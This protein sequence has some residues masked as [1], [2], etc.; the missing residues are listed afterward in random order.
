LSYKSK[1]A[2]ILLELSVIL[3]AHN[4]QGTIKTA[5]YSTLNAMPKNSELLVFLDAC[6][7]E[8]EVVLAAVLDSRLRVIKS[9]VNLGVSGAL[10]TLLSEA[11]GN[12]VARMDADD[13]CLPWRF[14]IQLRA[15]KKT[16]ADF[17]F[18][19]AVLFGRQLRPFGFIA[20][21][22]LCLKPDQIDMA[23]IFANPFVHPSMLAKR[24]ALEELGGY[25]VSAA[26]DYELWLRAALARKRMVRTW[27]YGL[28][29]RVHAGQLTQQG[30]W[31]AK[32]KTD[33]LLEGAQRLLAQRV[34]GISDASE[35]SAGDLREIAWNS[36]GKKSIRV[37]LDLL[38]NIGFQRYFKY[39]IRG[40]DKDA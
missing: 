4:A 33:A 24:S 14:K 34:L 11:K 38:R 8:T 5:V 25:S 16:D 39:G 36:N 37:K 40:D 17:V 10:N 23:L 9:K 3:P 29:Y 30:T 18:S 13:I 20:Q 22:P 28:L 35:L 19:N 26:E 15:L 21:M 31:Q 7:D 32:F 1:R 6:T 2:F 12:F 27:Q